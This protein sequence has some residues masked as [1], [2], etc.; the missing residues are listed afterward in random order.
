MPE[1][2]EVE[3]VRRGLEKVFAV[4]AIIENVELRRPD[5]REPIPAN[6]PDLLREKKIIGVRRRAKYLL[7]DTEAETVISHLGMSG[8]W[9]LAPPGAE[10]LHDHVYLKLKNGPRLAFNDP[11][12]FGILDI[13]PATKY[14]KINGS[15]I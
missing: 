4:N 6:L 1:L 3:T 13:A 5:L 14:L 12:R 7:L 15:K 11:R 10:A 2:P 9:R 8:T